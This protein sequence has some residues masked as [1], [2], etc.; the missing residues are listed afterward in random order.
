MSIH[1]PSKHFF[2]RVLWVLL[3]IGPDV[4]A[5]AAGGGAARIDEFLDGLVTLRA[6][7]D[8]TTIAADNASMVEAKGTFYLH[9]PGRFRWEYR[10]PNDQLIVADGDRV[11]LYD[12]ELQQVSHRD[13]EEALRGTPALILSDTGP[14]DRHFTVRDLGEQDGGRRLEL[15]PKSEESEV[16]RIELLLAGDVLRKVEMVDAFGQVTR[17]RFHKMERNPVLDRELFRFRPPAGIDVFRSN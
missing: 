1:L 10:T 4:G 12:P 8:Q 13:E 5:S 15:L 7:F 2:A 9:R 17:F 6:E 16:A 3:A 14:I 11:W